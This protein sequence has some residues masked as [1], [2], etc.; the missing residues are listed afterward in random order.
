MGGCGR[1]ARLAW[2]VSMRRQVPGCST[3]AICS[4]MCARSRSQSR[5]RS[6]SFVL[7]CALAWAAC[8]AAPQLELNASHDV[9]SGVHLCLSR[10]LRR[11]VHRR[12]ANHGFSAQGRLVTFTWTMA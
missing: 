1:N 3:P 11:T 7:T 6:H 2:M 10:A 8:R 12:A 9:A 4:V 5:S